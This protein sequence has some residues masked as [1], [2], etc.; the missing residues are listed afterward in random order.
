MIGIYWDTSALLKIYTPESDSEY[1]LDLIAKEEHPVFISVVG[2]V[3]I[4][5]ALN[6]KEHAGDVRRADATR[7]MRR[8]T[9]DCAEGRIAQLPCGD[10]MT[11]RAREIVEL[12]RVHP[13]PAPIRSLDAIHIASALSMRAARIVTTDIRMREVAAMVNLKVIPSVY[14]GG[15]KA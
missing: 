10:E 13:S 2:G 14:P 8:F 1:F 11:A 4:R 15:P 3:E 6:R 7:A 9:E 12:A 5:C